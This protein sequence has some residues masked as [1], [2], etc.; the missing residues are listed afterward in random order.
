MTNDENA[1]QARIRQVLENA[2]RLI[3]R[4]DAALEA[5]RRF[6]AERGIDRERLQAYA[7]RVAA[8]PRLQ[9]EVDRA[10]AEVRQEAEQALLHQS[11]AASSPPRARRMR[12]LV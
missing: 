10:M 5:G 4:V 1:R 11:F 2:D 6:F 7:D 3:G 9:A 8:S 12:S